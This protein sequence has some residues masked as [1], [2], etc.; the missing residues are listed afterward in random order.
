MRLAIKHGGWCS[1]G[2]V[3]LTMPFPLHSSTATGPDASRLPP[4]Q[5]ETG[6]LDQPR[7][8]ATAHSQG[9]PD[10]GVG[11]RTGITGLHQGQESEE[12][13]RKAGGG[14]TVVMQLLER[15]AALASLAEYAHEARRGDGR[16]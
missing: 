14:D 1:A 11:S 4:G 2:S 13:E 12:L 15:E 10:S 3:P 6:K 8:P 16:L 9:R 7:V 5:A